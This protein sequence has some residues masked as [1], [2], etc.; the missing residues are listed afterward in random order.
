MR[1]LTGRGLKLA[2]ISLTTVAMSGCG[3]YY[4]KTLVFNNKYEQGEYADARSY[5]ESQKKLKNGKAK[6]LYDLNFATASFMLDDTQASIDHFAEADRYAEDFSKNYAYEALALVSNP[7]VRPYELEYFENVLIH[8]YQALNYIKLSDFEGAI[9]ECRRMNLVL[10]ELH[11][12]FRRHDGRR[13]SRDAFGHLLMA[14]VYEMVGKDNDA[15]IAY[16]NALEIYESD[17]QPMY[18]TP[19]PQ[20]LKRGIIRSAYRTGFTQEGRK[21]EKKFGIA[22]ETSKGKGRLL[23]F[24]LDGMSP[25]KGEVSVD[26]VKTNGVGFASFSS[27]NSDFQVPIFWGDCSQS[28][29]SALSDFSYIRLTLPQYQ[30]RGVRCLGNLKINGTECGADVVENVSKI[31]HQSLK[32]R[33]WR[34]LGKAILRAATKEAMH[35]AA[36]KQNDYIGL[37]VNIANAV[38][39]KADTRC[40]MSLPSVIRMVD[41][42]LAEG[43]YEVD[44]STCATESTT[45]AIRDGKTSVLFFRGF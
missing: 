8:F 35:Q 32:D 2:L 18:G 42:E 30:D 15:F 10:D 11:D 3:T 28:E 44:Y 36:A 43:S 1:I 25:V 45:V 4:D 33:M 6:V 13:Y 39:D 16:R 29:R 27:P 12:A 14:V 5:L 17:Y 41:V 19:V 26:F 24:L 21:Y 34:E 20:C 7:T 9:V 22:Y 37:L 38:T 40:W 31:A 23:A